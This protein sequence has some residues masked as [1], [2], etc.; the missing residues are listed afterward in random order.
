[1]RNNTSNC[2]A[3]LVAGKSDPYCEVSMGSQEHRTRVVNNTLNPKWNASM[4]FTIRDLH[5]DVLCITVY[6]RD[7][8][9]P[10]GKVFCIICVSCYGTGLWC[11]LVCQFLFVCQ[12]PYQLAGFFM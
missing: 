9:S 3:L 6:D 2:F 1:M 8:Y 11:L 4:Q 7:L 10:N 12:L 5:Q